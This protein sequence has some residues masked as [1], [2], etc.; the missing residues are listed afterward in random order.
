MVGTPLLQPEPLKQLSGGVGHSQ[1]GLTSWGAGASTEIIAV[2]LCVMGPS[3]LQSLA[4]AQSQT[5]GWR[6]SPHGVM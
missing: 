3:V 5:L 2:V 1:L 6:V 4:G